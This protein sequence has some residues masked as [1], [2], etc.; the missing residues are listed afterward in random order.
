MAILKRTTAPISKIFSPYYCSE[1]RMRQKIP[2]SPY[3]EF[4]GDEFSN[5]EYIVTE[6]WKE[7]TENDIDSKYSNLS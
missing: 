1:C 3:C 7:H 5:F 6:D 4:C 2:L